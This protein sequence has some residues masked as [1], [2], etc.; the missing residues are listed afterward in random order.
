M[1]ALVL[2]A[3]RGE[4]M[5][6]LTET[7]PKP[8]LELCGRPLISWSLS[9]LR[10]AGIRDVAVNLAYRGEAI[11]QLLGDGRSYGVDIF[12]SQEP[13]GALETA[14][15]V[16][17]LR[18]WLGSEPFFL[19][20]ADVVCDLDLTR[21]RLVGS[22]LGCLAMVSNP[23]HHARGDFGLDAHEHLTTL[24]PRYTY[25]GW[26]L[27]RPELFAHLGPGRCALRAVLDR[28]IHRLRGHLHTGRWFDVGTAERLH[29]ATQQ[30]DDSGG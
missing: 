12:Y 5:G 25:S 3:G 14:G 22:D 13:P 27:F 10:A 21:L 28:S 15:A 7:T 29:E 24:P 20:S 11:R 18:E 1:K 8:L 16:V 2:A 17:A 4:R 26:G 9:A 19:L 23:A 6:V 30:L